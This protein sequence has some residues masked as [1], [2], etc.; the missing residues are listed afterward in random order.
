MMG[1]IFEI[2]ILFWIS[3][4][5]NFLISNPSFKCFFVMETES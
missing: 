3:I 2:D 5:L 1:T 4:E